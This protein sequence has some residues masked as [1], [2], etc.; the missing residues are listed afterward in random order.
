MPH[1]NRDLSLPPSSN[2]NIPAKTS[3]SGRKTSA[4]A[5][6][7]TTA[8]AVAPFDV[9]GIAILTAVSSGTLALGGLAY[10]GGHKALN[11]V[12]ERMARHRVKKAWVANQASSESQLRDLSHKIPST[13]P[14]DLH[15]ELESCIR[16]LSCS[17]TGVVVA[18]SMTFVLPHFLLGVALNSTELILQARRLHKLT[19]M[20]KARG[21]VD[22]YLSS[23]D[24]TFQVMSGIL[25][26][27]AIL[28]CTLGVD[29]DTVIEGF[30]QLLVSAEVPVDPALIPSTWEHAGDI[31]ELYDGLIADGF[32]HATS[33]IAGE[34]A[35]IVAGML[36]YQEMPTWD[37]GASEGDV[38]EIG[39][40][41][42]L[43]DLVTGK[44]VEDPTHEVLDFASR[45]SRRFG[46][47]KRSE[48]KEMGYKD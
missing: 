47:K 7:A 9:S 12:E 6:T 29:V 25:I 33:Q 35:N 36:G 20:A 39:A 1:S 30:A 43:V 34:P 16:R 10:H 5:A 38:L 15:T 42:V 2:N 17:V 3:H 32:L 37:S 31:S 19:A 22:R 21:G 14:M 28:L 18:G 26:K 8:L 11:Q 27:S 23:T 44:L 46:R 41:N 13:V 40:A 24:I 45:L 48:M 4:L